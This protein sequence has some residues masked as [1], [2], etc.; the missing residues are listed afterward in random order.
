MN[1]KQK[2]AE[3]AKPVEIALAEYLEIRKPSK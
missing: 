2:L 3:K 1:I